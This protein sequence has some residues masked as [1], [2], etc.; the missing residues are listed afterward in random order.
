MSFNSLT[1]PLTARRNYVV[2]ALL[3]H[4]TASISNLTSF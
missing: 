2:R 1:A 4:D 3:L